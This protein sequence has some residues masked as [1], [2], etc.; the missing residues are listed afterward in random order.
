M[1]Q[2][3]PDTPQILLTELS[4]MALI[5]NDFRLNWPC[6]TVEVLETWLIFLTIS[7]L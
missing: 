7:L 3:S 5:T 6:Y 1:T 2:N 4:Y